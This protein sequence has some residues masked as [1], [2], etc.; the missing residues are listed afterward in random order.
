MTQSSYGILFLFLLLGACANMDKGKIYENKN[1]ESIEAYVETIWNEK[2]LD[3]IDA[4]FSNQFIR[5]VNTI[6]LAVDSSELTANINVLFK[7]FPDLHLDI[8]YVI[9]TEN[10][11]FM[12]W[13]IVATNI[14]TFGDHPAT[15][16]K[17][18]I[19]GMS[20][21]DFNDDGKITF[22]NIYY[23]ELSLMQQLG[24]NLTNPTI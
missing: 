11:V 12:N 3:S 19:S 22:E 4:F 2:K 1:K 9:A 14:G 8:E 17:I 16:K 18:K 13:T 7:A 20:R 5:K 10:K 21:F 6:D 23:N 15:G 24:Y